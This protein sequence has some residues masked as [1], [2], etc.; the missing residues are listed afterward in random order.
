MIAAL[1]ARD[2]TGRRR[3]VLPRRSA[4]DLGPRADPVGMLAGPN[5]L[6]STTHSG[7]RA[8]TPPGPLS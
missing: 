4:R 7:P 8:R 2:R 5:S 6:L 3:S 1:N